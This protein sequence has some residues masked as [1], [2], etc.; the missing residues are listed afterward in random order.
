MET[1]ERVLLLG[2]ISI[3]G[4]GLLLGFAMVRA[5]MKAPVAPK[6]LLTVH[7]ASIIQGAVLLGLSRAAAVSD[8]SSGLETTAAVLVAAGVGLFALGTTLNWLMKVGDSFVE[9]P[10]GFRVTG[11]GST[12]ILA[13]FAILLVGVARGA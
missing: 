5:R 4:Y 7:L 12:A 8:L 13:G 10:I 3:L 1:S 6:Y 11:L 2:G 9:R